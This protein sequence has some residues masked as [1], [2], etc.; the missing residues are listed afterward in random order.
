MKEQQSIDPALVDL[1]DQRDHLNVQISLLKDSQQS[2]PVEILR[3]EG[4]LWAVDG[5][6]TK[7]SPVSEN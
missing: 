4:E 5:R 1:R 7:Y 2:D 6:I 3:L